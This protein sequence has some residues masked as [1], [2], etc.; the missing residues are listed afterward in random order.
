MTTKSDYTHIY[1]WLADSLPMQ[2][3]R[4]AKDMWENVTPG[5]VCLGISQSIPP[6]RFRLAPPISIS[7]ITRAATIPVPMRK[8]PA[9][10]S[11][12]WVL[13]ILTDT[14]ERSRCT[15]YGSLIECKWLK[16]GMCFATEAEWTQAR[17]ALLE[18]LKGEPE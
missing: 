5:D 13:Y 2:Y 18:L 10:G 14:A 16:T 1:Q 9:E 7:T 12:Y 6:G 11:A 17:D 8:T 3:Y 4:T 15:W